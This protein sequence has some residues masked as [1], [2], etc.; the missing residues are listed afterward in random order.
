M[1]AT[2]DQCWSVYCFL[3]RASVSFPRGPL[4]APCR[5]HRC[6]IITSMSLIASNMQ[7]AHLLNPHRR[8]INNTHSHTNPLR[9]SSTW[10][11][12]SSHPT[13]AQCQGQKGLKTWLKDGNCAFTYWVIRDKYLSLAHFRTWEK[14]HEV[15][16]FLELVF[17]P[18]GCITIVIWG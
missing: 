15:H 3:L 8:S 6:A 18:F 12:N 14:K 5:P 16:F 1:D 10:I 4:H 9:W 7:P 17:L 2:E 11:Q 13:G